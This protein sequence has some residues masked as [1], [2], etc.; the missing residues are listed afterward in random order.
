[1][2]GKMHEQTAPRK[3]SVCVCVGGGG[4]QNSG[5]VDHVSEL[6]TDMFYFKQT[7]KQ[8][9]LH[10]ACRLHF[11]SKTMSATMYFEI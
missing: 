9:N 5:A 7:S 8:I 2:P 3:Q 10:Q 1:M 4:H 11:K 6:R